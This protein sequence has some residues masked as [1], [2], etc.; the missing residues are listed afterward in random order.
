MLTC[1]QGSDHCPVYGEFKDVVSVEGDDGKSETKLVDI[2]NPPGVFNDGVRQKDWNIKD[3][4]PFSARLMPEF[5][6]RRSIKDM[7]KKP[8]APAA[9]ASAS[10]SQTVTSSTSQPTQTTDESRVKDESASTATPHSKTAVSPSP[11]RKRKASETSISQTMKK[12]KAAPSSTSR[13]APTKGQ[14]SLKGFF[15]SKPKSEEPAT[16]VT[17][18]TPDLSKPAASKDAGGTGGDSTMSEAA[19]STSA[20]H[21]VSANNLTS[22]GNARG[23]STGSETKPDAQSLPP[24]DDDDEMVYD[25]IVNKESWQTLFRKPAAPLC[26]SHEE[27][28][29][30]M[31]TRK[32]GENQGRSFWMCARPLGPSGTKE[33]GTQWRCGTFI[34]CSDFKTA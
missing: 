1:F 17:G 28:C 30:S 18:N 16:S 27:P 22:P 3:L 6:Q 14:K 26:E 29:K 25:P 9:P 20:P 15:Q 12:Q 34:W 31:Q 10:N 11:D 23:I 4:P 8:T 24:L 13:A 7:F 21:S 19:L 2:M 32:K 5:Y 33:K